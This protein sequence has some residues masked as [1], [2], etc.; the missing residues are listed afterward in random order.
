MMDFTMISD[1]IVGDDDTDDDAKE[2]EV[3]D[4]RT[5]E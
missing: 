5:Q 3:S 2:F 4:R 1:D